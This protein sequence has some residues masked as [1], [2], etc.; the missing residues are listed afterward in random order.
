M[1]GPAT[2]NLV[3][4]LSVSE[5]AAKPSPK[6][7]PSGYLPTLDGW[8]AIAVLMVILYHA[9]ASLQRAYGH[10]LNFLIPILHV[11]SD[12][13]LIFFSISGLLI[14]CRLLEEKSIRGR[15]DLRKFYVR[16]AFRILPPLLALL[17]ILSLLALMDKV[18]ATGLDRIRAL[19]F[20]SNY[21]PEPGWYLAHTWSLSVEEHFYLFWPV[22]LIILGWFRALIFCASAALLVTIWR[23]VDIHFL[24]VPPEI[25]FTAW[26]TDTNLDFILLGA[27][28][29]CLLSVESTR[30]WLKQWLTPIKVFSLVAGGVIALLTQAYVSHI[31]HPLRMFEALI[32]P[33]ILAGTI[34]NPGLMGI[35][36]LEWSWLRWLGRLSYSLYLWQQ[37]FFPRAGAE[38]SAL[39]R[40][41]DWPFN[42]VAALACAM[43]SFYL[44]ERPLIKIGHR[45]ARPVTEGR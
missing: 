33:A 28:A 27:A 25:G 16:R 29:G 13:V 7:V 43:A 17:V 1:P 38:S 35:R 30:T 23:M 12:G 22:I 5:P 15:I 24:I 34:L 40:F 32:I 20:A 36:I 10:D 19:F 2:E 14:T 21:G 8:R 37:L 3:G 18:S 41:Q 31:Q 42:L 39:G 45:L 4:T 9:I 6:K 26:R 44:I 11:G